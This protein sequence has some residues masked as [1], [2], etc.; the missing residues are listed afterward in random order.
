MEESA[1]A[2]GGPRRCPPLSAIPHARL[3]GTMIALALRVVTFVKCLGLTCLL[4]ALPICETSS[5]QREGSARMARCF[6]RPAV[7]R[8]VQ[9]YALDAS[10][11]TYPLPAC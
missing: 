10:D 7:D 11:L 2:A 1:A 8:G 5:E 3:R 6:F 9:L 4:A